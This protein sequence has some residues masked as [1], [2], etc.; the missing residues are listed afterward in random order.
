MSASILISVD[1]SRLELG[2]VCSAGFYVRSLA[3]DLGTVLGCGAHVEALRRIRS[4][5]FLVDA[6]V[7]LEVIEREG[8]LAAARI[9]PPRNMLPSMP[10]FI[11][12]E[13]AARRARHGRQISWSD[14]VDAPSDAAP[15]WPQ[16]PHALVRLLGSDGALL[17]IA[18]CAGERVLHPIVV[19]G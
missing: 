17:A 12:T 5:D 18:Q 6:A 2:I 3:H 16:A 13:D 1:R 11:V 9:V 10:G 14:V 15:L 7:P 19:L 8:R 4:G